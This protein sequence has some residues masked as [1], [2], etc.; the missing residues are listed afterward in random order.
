[1]AIVPGHEVMNPRKRFSRKE[2][3]ECYS[4]QCTTFFNILPLSCKLTGPFR[5]P[6]RLPSCLADHKR[7]TVFTDSF[8]P[9]SF[10]GTRRHRALPCTLIVLFFKR[11]SLTVLYATTSPLQSINP[12]S[13]GMRI[14]WGPSTV[15]Y[16]PL[17]L[18]EERHQESIGLQSKTC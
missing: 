8:F 17:Y 3:H 14:R 5:F 12:S 1:M 6:A 13:P 15:P 10:E 18:S 4:T 2:P 7:T 16:A 9:R 11:R